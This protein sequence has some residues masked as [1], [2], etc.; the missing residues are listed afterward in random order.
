M[1]Q[2]FKSPIPESICY[3]Y[4]QQNCQLVRSYFIFNKDSFRKSEY[5]K[6]LDEFYD[7]CKDYY[8]L[9]K[10]KY[11]EKKSYNGITTILRQIFNYHG[12]PYSS[13]IKYSHST[14][15]IEYYFYLISKKD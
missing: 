10:Q 14:Y 9:S 4:L 2:I 3:K 1:S 13:K 11:I 6:S 7:A 15:T 8:H 5:N 12:I